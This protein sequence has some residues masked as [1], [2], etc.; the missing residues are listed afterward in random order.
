MAS[1]DHLSDEELKTVGYSTLLDIQARLVVI[2]E[3]QAYAK[4]ERDK[5]TYDDALASLNAGVDNVRRYMDDF[6]HGRLGD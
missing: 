5:S 3:E 2:L 4:A 1:K 6:N